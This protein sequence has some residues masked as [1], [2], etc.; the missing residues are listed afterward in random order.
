VEP[1]SIQSDAAHAVS[2]GTGA[3]VAVV[4]SG[5]QADHPDL[6]GHLGPGHDFVQNGATPQDGNGHGTHVS[7]IIGAVSG[8][9]IGI[10]SVAPG[11]TILPVRVL[12]DAGGG[13]TDTVA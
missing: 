4:D 7:G 8:N 10:E 12:G 9:G 11:A 5:V 13:S 6:A 1:R 3:A 2:T